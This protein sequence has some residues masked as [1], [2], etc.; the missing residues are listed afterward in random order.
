MGKNLNALGQVVLKIQGAEVAL[1]KVTVNTFSRV[2]AGKYFLASIFRQGFDI[3]DV[4]LVLSNS[5]K[6]VL[7]RLKEFL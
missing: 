1:F 6:V 4:C 5:V 7:G 2:C 3:P